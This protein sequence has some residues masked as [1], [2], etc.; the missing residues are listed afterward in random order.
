MDVVFIDCNHDY[1]SVTSDL[2]ESIKHLND[3]G[4]I[5]MDDYGLYR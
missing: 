5:V 4:F 1:G 2:H 3:G